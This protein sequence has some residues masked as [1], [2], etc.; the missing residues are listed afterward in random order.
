[1]VAILWTEGKTGSALELERLWNRLATTHSFKLRCAYP[2][3][4]FD[5]EE[6]KEPFLKI[7]AE[8]SVVIPGENYMGL[9]D[10]GQ[11]LRNISVL[12][13]KAQSLENEKAGREHAQKSLHTREAELADLLENAPEG[14]QQTGPDQR[15]RW[16]NKAL[17]NLLGFS[18]EEFVGHPMAEFH[19]HQHIF[20]EFWAKLM[21]GGDLYNFAGLNC[22]VQGSGPVANIC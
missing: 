15:I 14:I 20:E 18:A 4:A 6:Y 16:A 1:M 22:S 12:Q 11:R 9:L 8:H 19:A 5:R 21:Q 10:E 7:C 2:M 17:L 3:K 13:Q